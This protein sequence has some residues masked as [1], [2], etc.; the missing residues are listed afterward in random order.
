V[1]SA[2]ESLIRSGYVADNIFLVHDDDMKQKLDSY[3]GDEWFKNVKGYYGS[4]IA[5]YFS[6]VAFYTEYLKFPAVFG[7]ISIIN[8]RFANKYSWIAPSFFISVSI[9]STFLI[10]F[11]KRRNSSLAYVWDIFDADKD[12]ELRDIAKVQSYLIYLCTD[13]F[14]LIASLQY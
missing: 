8:D 1:K 6:W 10:E 4:Q 12:S 2:A 14:L 13:I 11:W 9:W 5:L 3:I 7:L